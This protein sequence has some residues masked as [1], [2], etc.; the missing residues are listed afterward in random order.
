MEEMLDSGELAEALG[1]PQ[2][3][4]EPTTQSAAGSRR[5]VPERPDADRDLSA[6]PRAIQREP[7][8]GRRGVERPS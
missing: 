6:R 8:A 4:A 7:S 5:A 3:E 1:V 2:P